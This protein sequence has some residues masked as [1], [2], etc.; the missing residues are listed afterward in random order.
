MTRRETLGNGQCGENE[1]EGG[2]VRIDTCSRTLPHVAPES[3][4]I[5][6][7]PFGKVGTLQPGERRQARARRS[8]RE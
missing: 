1:P 3:S 5:F 6:H 8:D 7:F 2:G 4:V